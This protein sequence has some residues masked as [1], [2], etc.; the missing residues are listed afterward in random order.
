[1][2]GCVDGGKVEIRDFGMNGLD[3]VNIILR[4]GE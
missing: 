4:G 1:M 2:P 3:H